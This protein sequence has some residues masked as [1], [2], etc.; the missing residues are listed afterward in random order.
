MQPNRGLELGRP[1][2]SPF[3]V[4]AS[5]LP[6]GALLSAHLAL[7]A[8]G[9]RGLA[10][11]ILLGL[12]TVGAYLVCVVLHALAHLITARIGGARP[13]TIA[14][15]VFGDVTEPGA[16]CRQ[17]RSDVV[18]AMSGPAMSVLL[19]AAALGA[20]TTKSGLTT[21][22]L[23]TVG[24][25]NL[26]LAA[27]NLLPVLP[28]DGGRLVAAGS[29]R[30]ARLAS[31][32]GKLV[33]LS[34]V[35][36]GGWLLWQGPDLVDETAFGLWLVLTGI[37]VFLSSGAARYTT[38]SLPRLD[39]QTVGQ[40]ARPFAGRIDARAPA[41]AAGGPYAVSDAGRLAGVLTPSRI[42]PGVRVADLMVP[43][44]AELGMRADAPLTSAL[45][46]LSAEPASVVVVVDDRGV[47]RG[48]L[49]EGAVRAHLARN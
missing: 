44:T 37:F 5:W 38:A 10:Q 35:A 40:W 4:H 45:E 12:V 31:F 9:D 46:R 8:F 41:P 14:I 47:V 33:A 36:A 23:R 1:F 7:A 34:A 24:F 29:R 49:D 19:G 20:A 6:A 13:G 21:D 3:L 15:F 32:G 27:L 28:L 16:P 11:A 39:G 22:V 48:V 25:A 42:R 18:A 26:A 30:R 43:W 17:R 2:G